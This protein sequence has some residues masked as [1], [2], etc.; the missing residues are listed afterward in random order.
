[1]EHSTER[2]PA[3]QFI[4]IDEPS[5]RKSTARTEHA[6]RV[7]I[8]P[9]AAV[10]ASPLTRTY[11]KAISFTLPD[12]KA[13]SDLGGKFGEVV[14][15]PDETYR[16]LVTRVFNDELVPFKKS[17]IDVSS[18]AAE[19]PDARMI[20]DAAFKHADGKD[21]KKRVKGEKSIIFGFF[22][23]L[24]VFLKFRTMPRQLRHMFLVNRLL[25]WLLPA[26]KLFF[27]E[28][29]IL[30]HSQTTVLYLTAES[31]TAVFL[32]FN[33]E[34]IPK[35]SGPIN[36]TLACPTSEPYY[37][38]GHG[39]QQ[40]TSEQQKTAESLFISFHDIALDMS[41]GI[42]QYAKR[43]GIQLDEVEQGWYSLKKEEP[44]TGFEPRE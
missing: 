33:Y 15:D 11:P 17:V 3:E 27:L 12:R 29:G 14:D 35:R 13:D 43:R 18:A 28:T 39:S 36:L 1:M 8:I 34:A 20:F 44:M 26:G 10:G 24:S 30:F 9:T 41:D 6:Y 21:P 2:T 42:A 4:I 19:E 40:S 25:T 7:I 5:S 32:V 38:N 16:S 22:H 23:S 31:T 37:E